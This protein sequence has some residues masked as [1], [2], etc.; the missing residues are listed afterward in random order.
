RRHHRRS[1]SR[2]PLHGLLQRAGGPRPQPSRHGGRCMNPGLIR[3]TLR[4]C[5]VQFVLTLAAVTAWEVLFIRAMG[6][7]STDMSQL[8]LKQPPLRRMIQMLIGYDLASDL[9][10]PTLMTI[11]LA[12]PLLYA[13]TWSFILA[14]T[15]RVLAGEVDRGTA[16]LLLTLPVSRRQIFVSVSAV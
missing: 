8:W 12:P 15:S 7:F 5:L 4:D 10:P 14:V 9:T 2:R 1:R 11:G 3:K 13:L 16:D 6:E